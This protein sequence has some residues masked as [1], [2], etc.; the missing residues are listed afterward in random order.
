VT[1]LQG[2]FDVLK[3]TRLSFKAEL[4]LLPV[5]VENQ[6]YGDAITLQVDLEQDVETIEMKGRSIQLQAAGEY[7]VLL[8]VTPSMQDGVSV[9]VVGEIRTPIILL[10]K[11]EPAPTAAEPAPTAAREKCEPA[12]TAASDADGDAETEGEVAENEDCIEEPAPTAAD[13]VDDAESTFEP[14]PTAAAEAQEEDEAGS[15]EPAPTAAEP[16]PTAAREKVEQ[17]ILSGLDLG[18]AFTAGDRVS[19]SSSDAYEFVAGNVMVRHGQTELILTWDVRGWL[20]IMFADPLGVPE[21]LSYE[22]IFTSRPGFSGQGN[23]F[24]VTTR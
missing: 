21:A 13:E 14:A 10:S 6:G 7:R 15:A 23:D 22:P 12:P 9:D 18:R 16:A 2:V 3:I 8:R 4:F 19:V 24:T 5:D 11:A 17:G 1:G 20:R